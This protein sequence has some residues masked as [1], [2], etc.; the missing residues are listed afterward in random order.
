MVSQLSLRLSLI[1]PPLTL[2]ALPGRRFGVSSL[3]SRPLPRTTI[4]KRMHTHAK[5]HTAH[6]YGGGLSPLLLSSCGGSK[7]Q[8]REQSTRPPLPKP[9]PTAS[10]VILPANVSACHLYTAESPAAASRL[11]PAGEWRKVGDPP[12]VW[13]TR[14]VFLRPSTRRPADGSLACARA[15]EARSGEGR[16][17]V[18]AMFE[19]A[20]RRADQVACKMRNALRHAGVQ[21]DAPRFRKSE[22]RAPEF[23]RPAGGRRWREAEQHCCV[24][25]LCEDQIWFRIGPTHTKK[26][27]RF[28]LG[29]G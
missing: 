19:C 14:P 7:C 4:R 24:C 25:R 17:G 15:W 10:D 8:F 23:G 13:S 29:S 9:L 16:Q 3:L 6:F 11:L 26:N 1:S 28:G 22:A 2:C 21:A 20:V 12:A 27:C 5:S 18:K